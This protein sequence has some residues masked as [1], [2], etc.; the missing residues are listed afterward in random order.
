[1][2]TCQKKKADSSYQQEMKINYK[3]LVGVS[4]QGNSECTREPKISQLEIVSFVDE[5][6][7]RFEVAMQDPMRVAVQ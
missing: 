5:E 4:A 7:L 1:V 2:T 3:N 6:I